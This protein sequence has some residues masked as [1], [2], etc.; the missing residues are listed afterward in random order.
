MQY[1][2]CMNWGST[3]RLYV[4]NVVQCIVT[5]CT[6]RM[7]LFFVCVCDVV[8]CNGIVCVFVFVH[9]CIYSA[10]FLPSCLHTDLRDL[11]WTP[12]ILPGSG[13]FEP[14]IHPSDS[15]LCSSFPGVLALG[16]S[17]AEA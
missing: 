12:Q 16:R 5:Q 15:D 9:V 14:R 11:H 10:F 7:C 3:V 2:V 1:N 4:R 13:P 17:G 6:V 8:Y